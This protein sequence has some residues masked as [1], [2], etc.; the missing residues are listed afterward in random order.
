MH[1]TYLGHA[2]ILAESGGT[3]ILMDPW[4]TD[5]TYHG[6]WWHFPPLELGVRDLPRIDYL[7][8]S[9]EH[10]DHFDPP[11]L[12]QLDKSIHVI[13]ANY[14]RKRFRDRIAAL[15]FQRITELPYG[16]DFACGAGGLTIRL[17]GPDRP[18]DDSAILLRDGRSTVMNVNDC[19]LDENTLAGLGREHAIDLAFLTFTGASQYPGCFDFP[20]ASKIERALYS[21]RSHLEEFVHWARLLDCKRVVPAAGNHALLAEDQLF[22]NTPMYANTPADAIEALAAGAPHIEGLQMNPGDTWSLEQ[23]HERRKPAPDW[24]R[25]MEAIEELGRAMRAPRAEYFAS[26]PPAP[27]DLFER[28]VEYFHRHLER[29]PAVA[30]AINL[31]VQ[32]TVT[33]PQGGDWA[34][35]FRKRS[36]WVSRGMAPDWNLHITIPDA[37]VYK[38][39]SE[40]GVWDDII[41]SFRVRLARRPDRYMKEF[42]TWFCKL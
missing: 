17:I 5:P 14:A 36:D 25:R 7:Y 37:L 9:H 11:T 27:P 20:L 13:I 31:C 33:G 2:A 34:I 35:D 30:P 1:I 32:W 8:I 26:E 16:S 29:D 41:L 19:H 4:L 12:A 3:R 28:F 39:V 18:W 10:C 21:K 23:G 42:W 15:G 40:Q 24:S 6:T 38:G 22:L